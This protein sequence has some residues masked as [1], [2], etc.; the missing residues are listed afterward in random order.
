MKLLGLQ[1]LALLKGAD[2]HVDRWLSSWVSEINHANWKQPADVCE[3]FPSVTTTSNGMYCFTLEDT[4]I[5]LGLK[6]AF[7]QGIAIITELS[8]K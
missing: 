2:D 4:G 6:I 7:A 5:Q 3:Q 1:K 8:K